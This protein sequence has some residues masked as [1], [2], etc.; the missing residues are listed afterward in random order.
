MNTNIN[1][2]FEAFID[3][4][5]EWTFEG[6]DVGGDDLQGLA[7]KHSLIKQQVID[8]PC[9]KACTCREADMAFP[10]TCYRKTYK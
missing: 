1:P 10:V 6:I 4:I 3:E 8:K 7:I 2:N 5:L 9:G